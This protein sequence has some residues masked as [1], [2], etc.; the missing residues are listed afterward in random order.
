MSLIYSSHHST[1]FCHC[2]GCGS[3]VNVG[4]QLTQRSVVEYL[5]ASSL[6]VDVFLG[7]ILNSKF[8]LKAVPPVSECVCRNSRWADQSCLEK[9]SIISVEMC[10]SVYADMWCIVLH[11]VDSLEKHYKNALHL[12]FTR[13][14]SPTHSP[15][16]HFPYTHM[17]PRFILSIK[18]TVS[19]YYL[20][21][22]Y[23][24]QLSF[25]YWV[26]LFDLNTIGRLLCVNRILNWGTPDPGNI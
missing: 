16:F 5:S 21:R 7:K 18:V 11:V 15:A 2:C 4:H 12:P 9:L 1:L 3:V 8:L 17:F 26:K 10:K 14:S 25:R 19:G 22:S 13:P 24:P 20:P 6:H 23:V